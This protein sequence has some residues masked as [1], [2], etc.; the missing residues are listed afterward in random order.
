MDVFN[1]FLLIIM[2][3]IHTLMQTPRV[4]DVLSGYLRAQTPRHTIGGWVIEGRRGVEEGKRGE[5]ST[6]EY[7]GQQQQPQEGT[8][9]HVLEETRRV[10]LC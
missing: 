9:V 3:H 10:T 1:V 2:T 6:R 4:A 5:A 7:K 8:R